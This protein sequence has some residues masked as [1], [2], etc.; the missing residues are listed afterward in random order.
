MALYVTVTRGADA[1]DDTVIDAEFLNL[2]GQPIIEV[3]GTLDG[4]GAV[5]ISDGSIT[6]A[7]LADATGES[8]GVT[9]IKLAHMPAARLKGNVSAI[10]AAPQDLTQAQARSLLEVEADDSTLEHYTSS[11]GKIRVKD[12]GV[13]TAKLGALAVTSPKLDL[14]PA[15]TVTANTAT[16]T[17]AEH[18]VFSIEPTDDASYTLAWAAADDGKSVLVRVKSPGEYSLEF[19]VTGETALTLRWRLNTPITP[20]ATAGKVDLV[21]FTRIGANVYASAIY[22]FEG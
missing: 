8:S 16:L 12:A 17:V 19:A 1:T 6:T 14:R 3:R 21:L 2:L 22:G 4:E 10:A 15:T 13:V 9:N 5:S 11:G 20:T 18:L 7:K